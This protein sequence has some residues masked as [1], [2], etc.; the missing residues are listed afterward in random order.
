M[1]TKSIRQPSAPDSENRIGSLGVFASPVLESAF[2]RRHFRDDVWLCCFLVIAAMVRVSL[3]LLADY[4]LFDVSPAFWSMFASRLIFLLVSGCVLFALRRAA[5]PVAAD[6][7]F[8]GWCFLL[9]A[10]TVLALSARP[11]SNT[12]LLMMSFGMI[13]V[14]YCLTPLAL[15]HQAMLALSYSVAALYVSRRVDG[16][17][18]WGVSAVY[19][20]SNLFGVVASWR[21]NH[22]RREAFLGILREAELRANLEEAMAEIRTL[23]G[24][25]C[26]CAWCKRIRDEAESWQTVET[27]VQNRTHASFTHGICPDCLQSQERDIARLCHR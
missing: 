6:R 13:L 24:L 15:S 5:S 19:A 7:F 20:L 10:M 23:R 17:T 9:S 4:Q 14:A 21:L 26:I 2:R 25:H 27:Y 1:D 3:L 11:P 12:G 8:F 18:L 22:R 16:E